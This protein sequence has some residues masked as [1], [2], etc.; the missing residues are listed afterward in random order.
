MKKGIF[1]G[2]VGVAIVLIVVFLTVRIQSE[3]TV[4]SILSRMNED[5]CVSN[6]V[7]CQQ[8]DEIVKFST[9]DKHG[10]SVVRSGASLKGGPFVEEQIGS[11]DGLFE[12][13]GFEIRNSTN[14]TDY[15]TH[16]DVDCSLRTT[17][18]HDELGNVVENG[19]FELTVWCSS[20][21]SY[22]FTLAS[23]KSY[24]E[25]LL[26]R[27]NRDFCDA[28][29]VACQRFD[30]DMFS[31]VND[32]GLMVT[33]SGS[34]LLGGTFTEEQF[35]SHEDMFEFYGFEKRSSQGSTAEEQTASTRSYWSSEDVD[36]EVTGYLSYD[37]TGS[38]FTPHRYN[39]VII[40]STNE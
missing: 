21:E 34:E 32:Q 15:W 3:Y 9:F 23:L 40:C 16:Q 37:T 38:V 10:A 6:G 1:F 17:N 8:D 29:A 14:N 11:T 31:A 26:A 35:F 30:G 28:Y 2:A 39:I 7:E 22:S 27:I 18:A 19:T 5:I 12:S 36:C 4:E 24:P 20:N 25:T 33:R 13:Y